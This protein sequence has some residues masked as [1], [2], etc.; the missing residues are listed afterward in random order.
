[1]LVT[2]V[3]M[4]RQCTAV[5]CCYFSTLYAFHCIKFH[6]YEYGGVNKRVD[7]SSNTLGPLA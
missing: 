2:L 5:Y 7:E 1:M 3:D 4:F 6:F